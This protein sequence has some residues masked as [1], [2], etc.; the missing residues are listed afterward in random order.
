MLRYWSFLYFG[1]FFCCSISL[2]AQNCGFT[3]TVP[4]D[5][6]ICEEST[7]SLNGQISGSY[8]SYEWSGTDGFYENSNLN[9]MTGVVQTTTYTLKVLSNPSTNLIVNGDFSG[10]NSGFTTDYS[11]VNDIPGNQ[12]EMYPEGTYTVL[13]NPNLVHTD[14]DPCTDH[15]GGGNMMVVNGASALQQVW[16]QTINVNPGST[17][18]FQAFAT[19]VHPSSP[20]ILQFSIDGMLL[21]S[22]FN[23]SGATC[24][25]EEFYE[26]WDSGGNTTVELCI[27]NQNTAGGGNDFA[28]DDIFFGE[29]CTDEA[30]FDVIF[31]TFDLLPPNQVLINCINNETTLEATPLPTITGYGYEWTTL[32]GNIVGNPDQKQITVDEAGLYTVNVTNPYGCIL[33]QDYLVEEDFDKPDVVI[34]GVPILDCKNQTTQLQAF[35][36]SGSPVQFSWTLPGQGTVPGSLLTVSAP[37]LYQANAVGENGCVGID[38]I[39]VALEK[40]QFVYEAD[41]SGLVTCNKNAVDIFLNLG[42][43]IDSVSWKGPSILSQNTEKDT[44]L[45]NAVGYYVFE[46]FIGKDCS[47]KDSILV[48]QAPPEINYALTPEDTI[49]CLKKS[50]LI[51]PDSLN[52]VVNIQWLN[53]G[54]NS[55]TLEVSKA[56]TYTFILYDKNGCTATDSIKVEE[57]LE[58]PLFIVAVD[59]INCVTNLGGFSVTN[60][61]NNQ[62]VWSGQGQSF[63]GINPV[64]DKP[65]IYTVTATGLNGCTET[66]NLEL[67]SSI[68]FPKIS[69]N[70]VPITCANPN[71]SIQLSASIASTFTWNSNTTNGSGPIITSNTGGSFD[72]IATSS[73]GCK[74]TIKLAIPV[75]T[76]RPLI[77]PIQDVLLTCKNPEHQLI[78]DVSSYDVYTVSGPGLSNIPSILPTLTQKGIY[79]LNVKNNQN[80]CTNSTQ[81]NVN[82][83]KKKPKFTAVAP[84][85]SCKNPS[86]SLSLSGDA[87]LEFDIEGQKITNGYLITIA[88]KYTIKAT[89]TAGCD[90]IVTINVKGNFDLPLISLSPILLNCNVSQRW[91]KDQG[92]ETGLTYVWETDNLT[93]AKDSVLVTQN[94]NI[95]LVATNTYGCISKLKADINTDFAKPTI[96]IDGPRSI[97]CKASSITL[98]GTTTA[99][100]AVWTWSDNTGNLGNE[101]TFKVNNI[102]TYTILVKNLTNGCTETTTVT[103]DKQPTPEDFTIDLVQ[104]LCFGDQGSLTWTGTTGGT[105]PYSLSINNNNT[106]TLNKKSELPSGRFTLY[107]KDVNGCDLEK[108]IEI[109]SPKDFLVNAGRDTIIQLSTSHQIKAISDVSWSEITEIQWEPATALSCTDCPNPVATPETDTEYTITIK[110]KNGCVREDKVKIRVKSDKGWLAPNIFYPSSSTGNQRFTIYPEYASIQNIKTL[111]IYDRWGNMVFTTQNIPAGDANLGWDGSFDGREI[112]PGVFIWVAEIEYKDKSSEIAKGDVT[113]IK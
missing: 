86:A 110:D 38:T 57:D 63:T 90:T 78:L 80:G 52:G 109:E 54:S 44:I 39:S 47:V 108:L 97:P 75:D 65:G 112:N 56:G 104:P 10:G 100:N 8:F 85:L 69:Q 62:Y 98:T 89:N 42:S 22:P 14:F 79:T 51:A 43:Q 73:K 21:G 107:L 96:T 111:K 87:G 25:W 5:M 60:P 49:T 103:I 92:N 88:G 50:V 13:N 74:S 58:K 20:A 77:K 55:G 106:V 37:G 70:I 84:D 113:V 71:G 26:T 91:I 24:A 17:Y 93:I 1:L 9:P 29:L 48:S 2:R 81:F 82:E 76:L 66:Q 40:S 11:F 101:K 53:S 95:T 30:S 83:D 3:I 23:L 7:I 19:S 41:S 35:S 45:V 99:N 27:T 6:T 105:A 12:L 28:I 64:F 33:T 36:P 32:N 31:S 46:L 59:T 94:S 61:G 67:P 102:G 15:S 18:V 16:C 68:D 72:I 34:S 4:S